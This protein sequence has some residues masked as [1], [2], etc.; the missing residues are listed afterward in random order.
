MRKAIRGAEIR[1]EIY[2]Q[3]EK[4]LCLLHGWGG[5][6]ESFLPL[7]RDLSGEFRLLVPDFPGNGQSS[8]PPEPWSVTEYME[9]TAELIQG[10]GFSGCGVV[11]HSFGARVAILLAAKKP[12]LVGS[13]LLTG[14]AGLTS[15]D[16]GKKTAKQRTYSA[17]KAIAS[18]PVLP[19][20]TRGD[21]RE[22]LIQRFGSADYKACTPSMRATFNRVIGQ[23]L[24]A[25]LPKIQSPVFLFWGENDTATPLWM[26]K[27]MEA[28]IPDAALKVE[29]GCGHFAYL[30]R[31]ESFRSIA[32]ALFR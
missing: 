26:G 20:K 3:G 5:S 10:E 30:E 7:I 29:P 31:Y 16:S 19:A 2:G 27:V 32:L 18:L 17:L 13:M 23:D 22:R 15:A 24:R 4:T 1:Y 21:L 9:A 14:A 25:E 28:E 8:E 6:G 11:A 12:E